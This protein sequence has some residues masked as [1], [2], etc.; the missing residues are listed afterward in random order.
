MLARETVADRCLVCGKVAPPL[1]RRTIHA[2]L[3]GSHG[4]QEFFVRFVKPG[5]A[6]PDGQ[7]LFVCKKPCF[8]KLEQGMNKVSAV[9]NILRDL[10]GPADATLTLT[11]TLTL[12]HH[13][14]HHCGGCGKY[15]STLG[16]CRPVLTFIF[17][18]ISLQLY[19]TF[20]KQLVD[21]LI[22]VIYALLVICIGKL[23]TS[24]SL[25]YCPDRKATRSRPKA[26]SCERAHNIMARY[27]WSKGGSYRT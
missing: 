8:S 11:L 17:I 7:W 18:Q 15:I 6:F 14:Y 10:R 9:E 19:E 25:Y 13:S 22:S 16:L 12:T 2:P 26:N 4:I 23:M 5:F 21:C 24:P 3:S 20:G 1:S 27:G